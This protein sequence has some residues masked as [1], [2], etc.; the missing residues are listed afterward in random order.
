MPSCAFMTVK[1]VSAPPGMGGIAS[2]KS[3]VT[4]AIVTSHAGMM[5]TP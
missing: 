3:P 4:A 2:D 1:Q 5:A